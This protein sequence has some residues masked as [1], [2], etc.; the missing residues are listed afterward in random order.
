MNEPTRYDFEYP[1]EAG[2]P[3]GKGT[4]S[5]DQIVLIDEVAEDEHQP[6]FSFTVVNDEESHVYEAI[7]GDR[8][9]GAMPYDAAGAH[10]VVLRA[11]SVFPEFRNQGVATE[12]IR[13]VLDDVRSQSKTVTIMC[14]IVRAFIERH[15]D[16]AEIVDAEHPG[17]TKG[18]PSTS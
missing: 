11:T 18:T 5:Q 10:R 7:V 2:Y 3:D 13:R 16:Y 6:T 4:L 1:D 15:P 9:V 17:I 8:E 12:L 14:P